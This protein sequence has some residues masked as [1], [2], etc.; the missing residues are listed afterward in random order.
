MSIKISQI[1]PFALKWGGMV[2]ENSSIMLDTFSST[3]NKA[4]RNYQITAY[5]LPKII[6]NELYDI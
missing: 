6:D 2:V 5:M 1:L 4:T 3:R